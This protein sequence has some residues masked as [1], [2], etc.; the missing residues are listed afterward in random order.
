MNPPLMFRQ[1]GSLIPYLGAA[2]W[3]AQNL[4]TSGCLRQRAN[5]PDQ[6]LMRRSAVRRSAGPR[7]LHSLT[8]ILYDSS[9]KPL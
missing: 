7:K 3:P 8:P 1:S 5:I 9:R 6:F 2:S 4:K